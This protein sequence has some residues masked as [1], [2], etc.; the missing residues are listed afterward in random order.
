VVEDH[1]RRTP[2]GDYELVFS[3]D[4]ER[5][6]RTVFT[7]PL[8]YLAET[9]VPGTPIT[10][11]AQAAVYSLR[12]PD[13][14]SHRGSARQTVELLPADDSGSVGADLPH[15]VRWTFEASFGPATVRRT[16]SIT[17]TSAGEPLR[18]EV[19]ERIQYLG[20]FGEHRHD[21][22]VRVPSPPEDAAR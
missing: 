14:I 15:T 21:V 7:P 22:Y 12:S 9:M 19:D 16:T 11:D 13:R 3:I 20:P 5:G 8:L 10:S 4:F 2:S 6:K 18:H 17:V 1:I